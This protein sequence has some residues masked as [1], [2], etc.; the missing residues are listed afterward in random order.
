MFTRGSITTPEPAALAVARTDHLRY[1][2]NGGWPRSHKMDDQ[3]MSDCCDEARIS[4]T[5]ASL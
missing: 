2:W 3:F 5:L 4:L 1:H